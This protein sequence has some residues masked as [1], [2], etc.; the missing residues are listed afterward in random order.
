[1]KTRIIQAFSGNNSGAYVLVG[2]F[3]EVERASALAGELAHVFEQQAAWL[4]AKDRAASTP[5]HD[6]AASQGIEASEQ[7][8]A[9]QDWPEY[10]ELPSVIASGGQLL[11]F[12]DYAVTFPSFLGE[13]VYKRGGRVAVELD[14]SHH[15]IVIVHEIWKHG[16]WTDAAATEAALSA[17]RMSVDSD[18]LAPLYEHATPKHAG[19]PI[20]SGG[21]WPG[22]LRLVHAPADVAAAVRLVGELAT[23]HG[24][25]SRFSLFEAPMDE[26]DPLRSYRTF[27][28]A[29]GDHQVILWKPSVTVADTVRAVRSVTGLGLSEATE[30]VQRAPIE[31]VLHVSQHDAQTAFDALRAVG[32][33]AEML[34]PQH[35]AAK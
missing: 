6:Y 21:F 13:L 33:D 8:G 18:A 16:G 22:M 23:S 15:P 5:L 32:A 11:V 30:L 25:T 28:N 35:F 29:R 3:H 10:G 7:V 24:L 12:V 14:H 34:G 27:S 20:L 31:V 2:T 26:K 9:G 1:V 17:F 19:P 4:N